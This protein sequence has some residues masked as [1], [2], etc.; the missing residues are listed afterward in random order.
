M[1]K[2]SKAYDIPESKLNGFKD[3]DE[4]ARWLCDEIQLAIDGRSGLDKDLDYWHRIYEQS[5]TRLYTNRPKPMGADLTSP[6]GTQYVDSLHARTMQTIFGAEPIWTV[7]GWAQSADKAP[8]VEEFHQWTAEDERVQ[9]Y[10]DRAIQNSWIDSVGVLE[11]YEEIDLRPIRKTIWAQIQTTPDETGQPRAVFDEQNQPQL[12]QDAQGKYQEVPTPQDGQPAPVGAAQ[13]SIDSWEPVRVGPGYAIIDHQ[14]FL[15]LPA[16]AR[17]KREI[18]GYD[19][20]FYRR[21]T[22]LKQKAEEGL[23]DLKACEDIG[24]DNERDQTSEDTRVGVT[25]VRQEKQTAEKEL[26][27][28]A[29]LLDLDGQG[30]RWWV[31]TLHLPTQTC[32][33]LKYDDL[34][35]QTGF[36]RFVRF[37]PMPR[38]NSIDGLSVIGH[39]LITTIE[40][41][42]A[43]RN[44]RADR[45]ALAASAPL[46]VQ[47]NALYDPED[48]PFGAGAIIYVRDPNEVQQMEIADV[49]AS[50]NIWERTVMDGAERTMGVNDI[51]TG[52]QTDE[53]RTLGE[54]QMQVAASEVRMR[55]IT[56]RL[57]ES[58]EDLG[59]IRHAIWKR[60]IAQSG[61][62]D[63]PQS[64]MVGIEARGIGVQ[65]IQDGKITPEM[66]EG[67]FKFK[68]RGSVDTANVMTLRNDFNQM[69]IAI[70]SLMKMN[71][72]FAAYWMTPD[73]TRALIEQLLRVFR[74][75]DKQAVLG[76]A[77]QSAGQTA[78]LL[79]N[80]QIQQLLSGGM[81]AGM[82]MTGPAGPHP[83]GQPPPSPMPMGVQ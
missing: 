25:V 35:T 72:Q 41:H 9:S 14:D 18:W 2:Q 69:M 38:K 48:N 27:E 62:M 73:A 53:N 24:D 33:R 78:A 43:I 44:M 58:M 63:M 82:P 79:Q 7:E 16:H 31:A 42:T 12:A 65:N 13:V 29:F 67:K 49:P 30:E 28:T 40:E 55:L 71:P 77:G 23:Y 57:Q 50:I 15:V 70:G 66:L 17:D 36:G 10:V 52:A 19:K 11:C 64:V 21:Y 75:P 60:V 47:Q 3:Y 37:V 59:Q 6:L 46:K 80:P 8:F 1:A 26:H 68:P 76:P 54:R 39:K 34:G 5:R 45:S 20:R 56:A 4:F 32:L 74:F 22:Y 51:A 61:G 81:G 83:M